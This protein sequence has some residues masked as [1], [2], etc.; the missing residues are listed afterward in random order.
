MSMRN[1]IVGF[2]ILWSMLA[3][4]QSLYFPPVTGTVWDTLDPGRL[5][6]CSDRIDSLYQFLEQ[7]NTKAFI[8]LKDGKIVLE[9]YFGTFTADSSWYWASAGKSLTAFLVGMAQEDG[10]LDINDPVSD[11]LGKGWTTMPDSLE[12]RITVRHQ[13]SMTTG[14]NDKAVD[15]DCTDPAC[16]TFLADPGTRW[17][18]H[19]APYTLLHPVL[20]AATGRTVNQYTFQE[21]SLKTGIAGLWF[22]AGYNVVFG[23][24]ARSMARFGLLVLN[25][26][27]WGNTPILSDTAYFQAMVTPSQSLNQSY[28][29]LWWLNGQPTY[30]LPATQLVFNGPLIP[31]APADLIAGLGKNDQKVHVV[32]SQ[33]LVVV[34]LGEESGDPSPVP[35][36]FDNEMWQYINAL[37]CQ[38]NGREMAQ[39]TDI[40]IFPNPADRWLQITGN[41][42]AVVG[43]VDMMGRV[44]YQEESFLPAQLNLPELPAGQYVICVQQADIAHR[45]PLI[46]R[47]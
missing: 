23:S 46:I 19:N 44:V 37:R 24:K 6:W 16:L 14:L 43:I 29:Y 4:G 41:G 45:F 32:P 10:L 34:R 42:M 27:A 35:T 22:S 13:L 21:L 26:G 15:L 3:S 5:G 47:P 36:S 9:Q 28:G 17:S 25:K 8:I 7:R 20:E 1:W 30:M 18:Y 38:P 12:S 11:Y 39:S 2:G 33:Q 31:Q 40:S